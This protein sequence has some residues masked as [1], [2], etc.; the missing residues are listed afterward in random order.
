MW[1][2]FCVT[3]QFIGFVEDKAKAKDWHACL[4]L[5]LSTKKQVQNH[6]IMT[7]LYVPLSVSHIP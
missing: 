7:I 4:H 1:L 6:P 2:L 3:N 5:F